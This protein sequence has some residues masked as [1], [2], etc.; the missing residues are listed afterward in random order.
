M[1]SGNSITKSVKFENQSKSPV[2]P[3]SST[4]NLNTNNNNNNSI[5][6]GSNQMQS[7]L[8]TVT[9]ANANSTTSS[10]FNQ[11]ISNSAFNQPQLHSLPPK[12]N[13]PNTLNFDHQNHSYG[14][15]LYCDDTNYENNNTNNNEL[16]R[17]SSKKRLSFKKQSIIR[18][19]SGNGNGASE[20]VV[21]TSEQKVTVL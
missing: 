7:T 19:Y 3:A 14:K 1:N 4:T 13:K 12:S 8:A 18:T 16:S 21:D 9:F 11:S 20:L 17:Q 2:Q 15:V 5:L 10:N 6:N